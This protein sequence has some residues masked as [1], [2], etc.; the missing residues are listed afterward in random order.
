MSNVNMDGLPPEMQQR[1][2]DIIGKAQAAQPAKPQP[3]QQRQAFNQAPVQKQPT[4]MDHTIALRQE[5]NMMR[6]ELNAVAQVTEAVGTAVGQLYQTFLGQSEVT[7]QGGIDPTQYQEY[8][9]DN[10]DY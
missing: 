9:E 6:Q 10:N 7:D 8:V 1:I 3:V 5:V 2:A 4:L